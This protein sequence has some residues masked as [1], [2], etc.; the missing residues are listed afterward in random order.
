MRVGMYLAYSPPNKKMSLKQEGLGHYIA[1]LIKAFIKNGDDIT[2]AC[3][4]WVIDSIEELLDEFNIDKK[5]VQYLIPKGEPIL[6][7]LYLYK[8]L[9][10]KKPKRQKLIEKMA[11]S[12]LD[13]I[14]TFLI[15]IK[16]VVLFSLLIALG[17]ILSIFLMPIFIICVAFAGV[18]RILKFINK[19]I[20]KIQKDV[21]V[22]PHKF[23]YE[24]IASKGIM[25]KITDYIVDK[26]NP[27]V[28]QEKIRLASANEVIRY[29]NH[30]VINTD[31]WYCPMAFWPEFNKI[32]AT[33]VI[34][35]PDVVTGEFPENFS[36]YDLAEA[37]K[38]VRKTISEGTYF[39]TYCNYIK[40][41]I[42][43]QHFGK[44][45]ENV[46][47]IRHAVNETLPYINVKGAFVKKLNVDDAIRVFARNLLPSLIDKNVSMNM[48]LGANDF[49]FAF[50]SVRYIFYPS[51]IRGNKNILMLVKAYEYLLREK[52]CQIKLFL[53]CNYVMDK[54]LQEYILE[55]RLQMDVLSFSQVTNQQLAALYKCAELIVNPTLYEGGFPFTFGEGMSVGTP[56][57]MSCIPQVIEEVKGYN[58]ENMLFDPYDYKSIAERILYGLEN[59]QELFDSEQKMFDDLRKRDWGKVG[60]EYVEAFK[61]FVNRDRIEQE[62][63]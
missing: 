30:S 51:Q 21:V 17:I 36:K 56:S 49:R 19:K 34:C 14:I 33:K 38:K 63:S 22:K 4:N 57:V 6:Y 53:T 10:S 54:E 28:V 24:K 50:N 35:V 2:I 26:Y 52:E 31:I 39:I 44:E 13:K 9:K 23:L 32:K 12:L 16:N 3:P 1:E 55:K 29:I 61:Y 58:L 48:Y 25:K 41:S 60:E 42:V 59:R 27:T 62:A 20:F 43:V 5:K 15:S 8:V 11:I 46:I 7:K 18:L 37:T 45:C 47:A 40:D